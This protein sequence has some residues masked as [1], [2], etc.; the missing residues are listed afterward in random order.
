MRKLFRWLFRILL[1]LLLLIIVFLSAVTL[2]KIPIDLTRFKEPVEIFASKALERQVTISDSIVVSTSLSPYFTIDG[3]EIS[4]PEGFSQK[5]FLYLGAARIQLK[6]L[7]LLKR[8]IHIPE[9]SVREVR[10]NL[11]EEE[12]GR[13]SWTFSG[14]DKATPADAAAEEE[15]EKQR[16][17][18][19]AELSGDS[20]VVEALNLDNIEVNWSVPEQEHHQQ[21]KIE[22]CS[23]KMLPGKPLNVD[24]NG[25]LREAPYT[26]QVAI[27]SLDEFLSNNSSWMEINFEI[28]ETS[29]IFSGQVNLAAAHRSLALKAAVSGKRFN[30]LNNLLD[31]DLPPLA[32]YLVEADLRLREKYMEL[33]N[34]TIQTGE[35]GLSGKAV[36]D[37]TGGETVATVE[38]DSPLVQL[39]DFT[40]EDWSWKEEEQAEEVEEDEEQVATIEEKDEE[41]EAATSE[42][43]QNRKLLDPEVLVKF[44]ARL[45]IKAREVLSGSDRLGSG[46]LKME[47][48]DGKLAVNPLELN[49]PGGGILLQASLKPGTELSAASLRVEI[50]NFDI[51]ILVRRTKP[52]AK[53]GGLVN[54]DIDLQSEAATFDQMLANGNGYFDFSGQ[55]TDLG[56]GII[57]L[58]AVNLIA[59]I[60]SRTDE[61]Q[62]TINCAVGRWTVT[63]GILT[64]DIFFIDTSKIRICAKGAVDFK[65]ER[66]DL[67]IAPTPKKA[68]FFNLA[69]PLE[70]HGSFAEVDL[71]IRKVAL[72]GTA[73]KF[74]TSPVHVPLQRMV[75][76]KIPPDG[77]DA[78]LVKLGPEN[79]EQ[80][81]VEGCR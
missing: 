3:L 33:S 23:G 48:K 75:N 49:V 31:L 4:N 25:S 57:D 13:V 77:S 10:I 22:R 46:V 44:D 17:G 81:K 6:L 26:V 67:V 66:V 32:D 52:E 62:S 21:Y 8:K 19:K 76:E 16:T 14:Q 27:A 7:P 47:L 72:V 2:L 45:S 70:V 37:A 60:V 34:F 53:M 20:V 42:P 59:S 24:M 68:E 35:S 64:P 65:K 11:V 78:C 1:S 54:V 9:I 73:L 36:I 30:S 5:T 61:N 63:D 38:L 74:I 41:E 50:E 15:G 69:T 55:L 58:W 28:A 71:A 80:L 43:E 51:G 12:D 39:D 40:F 18:P 79:R 56:A 29:F